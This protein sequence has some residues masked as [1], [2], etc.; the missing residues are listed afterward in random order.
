M[1]AAVAD[2]ILLRGDLL[3]SWAS[4]ADD[5]AVVA[6]PW[7]W[8]GAPAGISASFQLDGL[9]E[10]VGPEDPLPIEELFSDYES[11]RNHPGVENDS[12]AVDIIDRYVANGWIKEFASL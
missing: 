11:F 2:G 6:T 4:W 7:L 9:L 10:P 5:P 12:E 8:H 3:H 1:E